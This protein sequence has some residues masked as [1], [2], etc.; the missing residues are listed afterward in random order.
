MSWSTHERIAPLTWNSPCEDYRHHGKAKVMTLAAHEFIRRFLQH[1][2]PDAF[3]RIRHYGFL[4]NGHRASKLALCRRLLD[5]PHAV[6]SAEQVGNTRMP[7]RP[8]RCPCCGG[9]MVILGILS[10]PTPSRPPFWSDTS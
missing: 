4:A 7:H 8:E 2:L 9:A 6:P 5:A 10:R 3:H 1:T